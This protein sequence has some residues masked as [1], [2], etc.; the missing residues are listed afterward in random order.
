M[1]VLGTV[2]LRAFNTGVIALLEP[3]EFQLTLDNATSGFLAVRV[4][5]VDSGYPNIEGCVPIYYINTEDVFA[6]Q[7]IPCIRIAQPDMTPAFDRQPYYEQAAR[8]PA[9]GATEIILPDGRRGWSSYETQWRA[10][11]YDLTYDITV[12]GRRREDAQHI[13]NYVLKRTRIPWFPVPVFDTIGDRRYYDGGDLGVSDISEIADIADR[14]IGWTVS[15]TVR[16]ELDF[17][18]TT[19]DQAFIGASGLDPHSPWYSR[20]DIILRTYAGVDPATW[21]RVT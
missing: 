19:V 11:P 2:D 20:Y 7:R 15:F 3:E 4:P 9:P 5:N 16:A 13:L 18:D 21:E 8:A 17:D 12:L 6:P 14:V 10:D 1:T